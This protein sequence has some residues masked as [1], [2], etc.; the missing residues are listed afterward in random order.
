VAGVASWS[1]AEKRNNEKREISLLRAAGY[2]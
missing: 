1:T 2:Q